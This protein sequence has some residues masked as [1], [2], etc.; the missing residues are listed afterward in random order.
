MNNFI[1]KNKKK[2][3]IVLDIPLLM[4]NK[5]NRKNDIIIFVDAKKKEISKRLEKR[6]N[7]NFKLIKKLKK[8]QL[9]LETKKKKSNYII[10]NNFKTS[11]VKK[12]VKVIKNKIL[13]K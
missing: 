4:E 12:S 3:I 2:R 8:F 10:K 9:S 13:K 6:S 11:S 1:I 5:I 7:F